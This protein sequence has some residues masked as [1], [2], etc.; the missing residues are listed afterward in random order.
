MT[1]TPPTATT[2]DK[3]GVIGAGYLAVIVDPTFDDFH[4]RNRSSV[5]HA[6]LACVAISMLLIVRRK[7]RRN[8][9][10]KSPSGLM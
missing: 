3:A 10:R 6:Y 1:S 7:N 5:R 9:Q 4:R 2:H 8:P